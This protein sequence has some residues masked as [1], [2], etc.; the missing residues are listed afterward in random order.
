VFNPF[1]E[2]EQD[3][4]LVRIALSRDL[5]D[6]QVA[7]VSNAVHD[8]LVKIFEVPAKDRFQVVTRHSPQELVY[9]PE[10]LGIEHGPHVA[11]VQIACTEGRSVEKKQALYAELAARIAA[12]GVIPAADVIVNL[13]EVKKENWSFGNG[14]AQYVT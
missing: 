8:S 1:M 9:A 3:M 11:L 6:R 14:I 12:H 7:D 2:K 13:V 4:P 10:Y 5:T